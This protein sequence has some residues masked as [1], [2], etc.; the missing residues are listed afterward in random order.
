MWPCL[1]P[2]PPSPCRFRVDEF[3]PR[4]PRLLFPEWI[5]YHHPPPLTMFE[6]RMGFKTTRYQRAQCMV[7]NNNFKI[8]SF[9]ENTPFLI[10]LRDPDPVIS[11][12]PSQHLWVANTAPSLVATFSSGK[13][14][15]PLAAHE[16]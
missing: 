14:C 5:L 1:L 11:L 6:T 10:I 16:A 4:T 12:P 15:V 2:P 13:S 9:L 8:M 7:G 3:V